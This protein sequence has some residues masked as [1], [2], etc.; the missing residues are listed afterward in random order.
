MPWACS[1]LLSPCAPADLCFVPAPCWSCR[2]SIHAMG[3]QRALVFMNFQQR[4]KDTGGCWVHV[5]RHCGCWL[6]SSQLV[7]SQSGG[8]LTGMMCS[9]MPWHSFS[10]QHPYASPIAEAKLAARNMSVA[11]LHG[12]LTKQ[13][14]QTTLAAF[15]RGAWAGWLMRA[16]RGSQCVAWLGE[17]GR[18][19]AGQGL[20][21]E[22][23]PQHQ[24]GLLAQFPVVWPVCP[25]H[26]TSSC[27][28]KNCQVRI[29]T[30]PCPCSHRRRVPRPD[31]QRRGSPRPGYPRVRCRVPSGAAH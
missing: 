3:V 6:C 29:S 28:P 15:R 8:Q 9:L 12:E 1:A 21:C 17:G 10:S 16:G 20:G 14:R 23:R 30:P 27:G 22:R 18:Q 13:Q 7:C 4:L 24:I 19:Q 2:R 25:T 26:L 11:S 31:C 5:Q